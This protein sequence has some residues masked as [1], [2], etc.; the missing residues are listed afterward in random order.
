MEKIPRNKFFFERYGLTEAAVERYLAAALSAGGD[1]AD[2]YFE[3][4][5]STSISVDES[6]VKSA[7]QGISAGCGVRVISGERTGYAYTDDL[8]PEKILHAARTAALIASGPAREPVVS[9]KENT[10]RNL[11]PLAQFSV[12]ADVAAKLELVVRAD[13]SA[14][15]YDPRIFQVRV[16]YGDEL[17][18]ILVIGSDG[19]FATDFQPLARMNVFCIAKSGETSSRGT[20]GGGGRVSLDFFQNEKTPEH[21]AQEAARQAIVQLDAR[22]APAGEMEVVLGPGWPGILLHEAV[23][24]GLEA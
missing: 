22:D 1:Y 23:G 4:L 20:S 7:T 3:Y 15:A 10:G 8:A 11:Y 2:L 24:H 5:T 18:R 13:K 14:R 12:D 16:G 17:R 9:L 6:L 21:F 19:T